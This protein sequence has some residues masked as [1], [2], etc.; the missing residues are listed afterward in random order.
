MAWRRYQNTNLRRHF[1]G[2]VAKL[3]EEGGAG[4]QACGKNQIR[5]DN[6]VT[7]GEGGKGSA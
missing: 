2:S 5:S 1:I 3:R 4:I 6:E 7:G